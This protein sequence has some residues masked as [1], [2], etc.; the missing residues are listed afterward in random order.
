MDT[1]FWTTI[2]QIAGSITTQSILLAWL[3][4]ERG[5]RLKIQ[6][7][8]DAAAAAHLEYVKQQKET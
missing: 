4:L 2:A 7:E 1:E 6:S 8:K 5:E 3:W